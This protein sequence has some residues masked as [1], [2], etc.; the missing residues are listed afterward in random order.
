VSDVIEIEFTKYHGIGNDFIVVTGAPAPSFDPARVRHLCARRTGIGADGV[1]AVDLAPEPRMRVLNA[2][3]SE[4]EM[5][6]NG[7]RCVALHL[8]GLGYGDALTIHTAAGPHRTRVVGSGMVAVEMR[9]A[10][11]DWIDRPVTLGA[12]ELRLS[13]VSLGNPH[14]VTFDPVG[15]ARLALGPLV[16]RVPA[17]AG[18]VNVGFAAITDTEITLHVLERGSGWTE[19]CGTG[20]CAAAV[21]AIATGRARPNTPLTVRL[22]GGRLTVITAGPDAPILM[23]GPAERVFAGHLRI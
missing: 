7:I 2:D 4:A 17:F 11:I 9:P 13:T 23:T 5:C 18:G 3:G 16:A 6:G 10:S 15:D 20:A 1:L 22:P 21:A 8:A 19:A 14:A 12:R